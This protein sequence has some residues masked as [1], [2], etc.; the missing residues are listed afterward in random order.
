MR[1]DDIRSVNHAYVMS[2]FDIR[3]YQVK[4]VSDGSSGNATRDAISNLHL[5]PNLHSFRL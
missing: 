3:T 5:V 4:D 2:G 1:R